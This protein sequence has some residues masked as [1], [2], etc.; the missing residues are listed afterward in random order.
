MLSGCDNNIL[1]LN[2]LHYFTADIET[3]YAFV[4]SA[5][6]G[7]EKSYGWDF[8]DA[9]SEYLRMGVP[10]QLWTLSALNKNF[11]VRTAEKKRLG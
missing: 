11:E 6:D 10:N 7:K 9:Q 2:I 5:A 1:T 8:Y 4:Y 3:L